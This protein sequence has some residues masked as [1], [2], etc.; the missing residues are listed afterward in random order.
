MHKETLGSVWEFLTW[1]NGFD[2]FIADIF[3]WFVPVFFGIWLSVRTA[4]KQF[5]IE[6]QWEQKTKSYEDA[7]SA[8]YQSFR[9]FDETLHAEEG[10]QEIS[11]E[12]KKELVKEYANADRIIVE[13][14]TLGTFKVSQ[15]FLER[16][17]K[18]HNRDHNLH[19]QAGYREYLAAEHDAFKSC[20]D[21]LVK[22]A[23]EDLGMK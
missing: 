1:V 19:P 16:L 5:L 20:I 12:L 7:I 13:I 3:S 21:D 11:E 17:K 10:E 8:V 18:L 15:L 9:F 4:L 22:L 23:K 14:V 6:K 2:G